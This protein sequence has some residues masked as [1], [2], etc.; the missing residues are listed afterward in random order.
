MK[1][2][3][4]GKAIRFLCFLSL[5][6]GAAA[7]AAE[8]I[9]WWDGTRD[10][11]GPPLGKL[12]SDNP[13]FWGPRLYTGVTYS[14]EQE[15]TNPRDILG[16]KAEIFGRRL[17][18]GRP[19]GDWHTPVGINHAPLVVIFDFK[20]PCRFTEVDI[21][22]RSRKLGTLVQV[23]AD[24]QGPWTTVQQRPVAASPDQVFHRLRLTQPASGRYL[25]VQAQAESHITWIEE[26]LVWGEGTVSPEYPENVQPVYELPA[27]LASL[28]GVREMQFSPEALE[29]WRKQLGKYAQQTAVWAELGETWEQQ[30]ILPDA[31]AVEAPLRLTMARNETEGLYLALTN[32]SA[33]KEAALQIETPVLQ[34]ADGRPATGLR[35]ELLLGGALPTDKQNEKIRILPLFAADNLLPENMMRKYLT[36]GAHICH[37]PHIVLPPGGAAVFLLRVT[38]DRCA[39]GRY[40]GVVRYRGGSSKRLIVEVVDVLLPE[41]DLWVTSW[42]N[43][44]GQFPYEPESRRVKDV[45]TNL[46]LG[47]TVIYGLPEPGSKAEMA[48]RLKKR[49][50]FHTRGL[51]GLYVHKGYCNLM[52]PED[53]TAEDEK[54]IQ[55]HVRQLVQK[56]AHLGLNYEEW[57]VEFWDE[58]QPSNIPLFAALARIVKK[59]DPHVNI[60]MNPLFWTEGV[61]HHPPEEVLSFLKPFYN[62]LIDISV[63]VMSLVGDNVTTRELWTH[64]RRVNAYYIHPPGRGGR[65]MSWGAFRYGFNGWGYYVYYAPQ[66]DP[67]ALPHTVSGGWGASYSYQMVFPGPHGPVITPLY[68]TMREG[69]EDY[70]LLT[71]LRQRGQE[72]VIHALLADLDKGTPLPSL[73]E[74]ALH[75]LKTRP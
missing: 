11:S 9:V 23:A 49:L 48:R 75:A 14:Y 35:A 19:A 13:G 70:R 10:T 41:V 34:R 47:V 36:N 28:P 29:Q 2:K 37:Y 4:I 26:I 1:I 31:A 32:T 72:N 20:R 16:D 45:Q 44:T 43:G 58:P 54:A 30:P 40:Q 73:R 46:Q 59:T 57:F 67:W 12:L 25:R 27:G 42:G 64:P 6:A 8:T 71:A 7:G 55:E 24:P 56:A 66:G 60:Y 52:K 63:P 65:K 15:P 51:P 68:E 5:I 38:T 61:G 33:T 69:W 39:P 21:C 50:W 17:L 18:D 53:I 3:L 22:S 62:E 74:R